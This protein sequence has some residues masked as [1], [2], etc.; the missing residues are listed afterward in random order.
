MPYKDPE[1]RKAYEKAWK[2]ANRDRINAC[3]RLSRA[4]NPEKTRADKAKYRNPERDAA[5]S[6]LYRAANREKLRANFKAW[7]NANLEWVRAFTKS[8]RET[9]LEELRAKSL[10]WYRANPEKSKAQAKAWREAN[11]ERRFLTSK[12]WAIRNA[13]KVNSYLAK[14]GASKLKATPPWADLCA[15]QVFYQA[16][17]D[18]TLTTGVKHEVDHIVPLRSKLVC[19][20]HVECNLQVLT[21]KANASKG[22]YTWPDMP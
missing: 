8:Y 3:R 16:S 18:A 5:T 20:L 21:A 22:N 2:K 17:A 6:K 1:K 12:A 7:Y 13:H 4:N 9:N 11:P 10:K 19:G 15:I 14:R